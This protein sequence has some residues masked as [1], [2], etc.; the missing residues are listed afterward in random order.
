[1][2]AISRFLASSDQDRMIAERD[3]IGSE[4][5]RIM[6]KYGAR[7]ASDMARKV[8]RLIQEANF[9]LDKVIDLDRQINELNNEILYGGD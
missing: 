9:D 8:D 1:M 4:M 5:M 6:D 2:L 3:R 7:T